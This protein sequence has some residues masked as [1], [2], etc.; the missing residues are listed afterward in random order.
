MTKTSDIT[1][2]RLGN[3]DHEVS[4]RGEVRDASHRA[5][6]T[7][8]DPET[9][10]TT[11]TVD[12]QTFDVADALLRRHR[13]PKQGQVRGWMNGN[14]ADL[15]I[16][17][18]D[19]FD[20]DGI[21]TEQKQT[22]QLPRKGKRLD[23]RIVDLIRRHPPGLGTAIAEKLGA[24][25]AEILYIRGEH[26]DFE[27]TAETGYLVHGRTSVTLDGKTFKGRPLDKDETAPAYAAAY[28][29]KEAKDARDAIQ[30]KFAEAIRAIKAQKAKEMLVAD[31]ELVEAREE[32]EAVAKRLG[33]TVNQ[34]WGYSGRQRS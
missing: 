34:V 15:W 2:R 3:T 1:W 22:F 16:G 21:I 28:R 6:P 5:V 29:A 19:W 13:V 32:V 11:V 7:Q 30:A 33:M 24:S 23:A 26:C 4:V 10:A 25:V 8:V 14:R 31:R 20:A 27:R 9:L 18:L 17:N 12:G